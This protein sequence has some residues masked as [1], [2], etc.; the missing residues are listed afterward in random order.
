MTKTAFCVHGG[1]TLQSQ[2]SRRSKTASFNNTLAMKCL[3]IKLAD[4][5]RSYVCLYFNLIIIR[6]LTIIVV[7]PYL[8]RS[9]EV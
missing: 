6:P 7:K 5:P 8:V 9:M 1:A 2:L 3:D 4:P